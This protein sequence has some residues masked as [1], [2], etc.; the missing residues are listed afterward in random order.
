MTYPGGREYLDVFV[1]ANWEEDELFAP[2][3]AI[4]IVHPLFNTPRVLAQDGAFTLHFDPRKSV[5]DY[6]RKRKQFENEKLDIE[7]LYWW[8]VPKKYKP[9]IIEEL[10]GLGITHRA[11][12]PDLDGIAKS[13]WETAV[14]W[15]K[16]DSESP[17]RLKRRGRPK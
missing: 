3:D 7:M 10:S 12:F 4:R 5:E 16:N 13:L 17:R 6:Y 11:L 14:L 15:N 8:K 9:T 2:D 1:V